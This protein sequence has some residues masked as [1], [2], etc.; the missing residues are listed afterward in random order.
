MRK[1]SKSFSKDFLGNEKKTTKMKEEYTIKRTLD[2]PLNFYGV[3]NKDGLW[4]GKGGRWCEDITKARFYSKPGPAKSQVTQLGRLF[5]ELGIPD[6]VHISSGICNVLDQED[7]VTKSLHLKKIK[8][9]KGRVSYWAKSITDL[10]NKKQYEIEELFR[11]KQTLEELKLKLTQ[12][13]K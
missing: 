4:L 3:M 10:E 8:Y 13:D 7:R 9:L 5:P 1:H 12:I 6:L 2:I 11:R